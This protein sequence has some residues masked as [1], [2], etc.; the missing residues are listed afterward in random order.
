MIRFDVEA[1]DL[2]LREEIQPARTAS[3]DESFLQILCFLDRPKGRNSD[4]LIG[5]T[6]LCLE[7]DAAPSINIYWCEDHPLVCRPD[8]VFRDGT[9]AVTQLYV[10]T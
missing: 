1:V 8:E 9:G 2:M 4:A 3:R 5:H 7:V 10:G 6:V